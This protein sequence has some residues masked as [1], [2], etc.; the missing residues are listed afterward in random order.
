LLGLELE[1]RLEEDD[2]VPI[3]PGLKLETARDLGP[4]VR[5]AAMLLVILLALMIAA[6]GGDV[7]R[8]EKMKRW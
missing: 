7:E 1:S 6:C 2:W 3:L 8:V 5:K 4:V